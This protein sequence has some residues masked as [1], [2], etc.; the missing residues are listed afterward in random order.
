MGHVERRLGIYEAGVED[1]LGRQR[2]G[3][4]AALVSAVGVAHAGEDEGDGGAGSAEGGVGVLR[5]W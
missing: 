3:D 2:E 5:Y 1:G 4:P